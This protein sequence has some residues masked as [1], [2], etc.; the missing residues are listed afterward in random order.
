MKGCRTG[1]RS[2]GP[3][4]IQ[5]LTAIAMGSQS[6]LVGLLALAT[7]GCGASYT[8][9]S[10]LPKSDQIRHCATYRVN[11]RG[12]I[13]IR[14]LTDVEV[15]R[16]SKSWELTY[17][18][19]NVVRSIAR[20]SLGYQLS[21][22]DGDVEHQ[23]VYF[24]GR[25]T[26]IRS[27]TRGQNLRV[28]VLFSN[29]GMR[30]DYV[31][32]W[33]RPAISEKSFHVSELRV[34]D[35]NGFVKE[36]RY[37]GMDGKS[38][39]SS[40]GVYAVHYERQSNGLELRTCFYDASGNAMTSR[41]GVHCLS[42]TNDQFGN[43]GE[44]RYFGRDQRPTQNVFGVHSG[45]YEHD[46]FG[47]LIRTTWYDASG[48]P[49]AT[50]GTP[51]RCTTELVHVKN[52]AI[53][54]GDCYDERNKPNL[55]REGS[56]YW[57]HTVDK[58]G[59]TIGTKWFGVD[60]KPLASPSIAAMMWVYDQTGF[61]T[62]RRY[63]QADGSLR[64]NM[65]PAITLFTRDSHGLVLLEEY[66]DRTKQQTQVFG[67][68]YRQLERDKY[69]QLSRESCL[70]AQ[71]RPTRDFM[72]VATIRY[73]YLDNGLLA[74]SKY[75]DVDGQPVV[76]RAGCA[77]FV[78]KYDAQG[79]EIGREMFDLQD[80]AVI[81]PRFRAIRTRPIDFVEGQPSLGHATAVAR[82]QQARQRLL[83]GEDFATV[84]MQFSDHAISL[85]NPGDVGYFNPVTTKPPV[86]E[87][88][89]NLKVGDVST[90]VEVQDGIHIFQRTE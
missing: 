13:C 6:Y 86:R 90:V 69:R 21:D 33:G 14:E 36:V 48:Q 71:K 25:L 38:A 2:L 50:S 56:A 12:P 60:G 77:K 76:N 18:Q 24:H 28:R 73:R 26:E 11:R 89:E 85:K 80:R 5:P 70:N 41:W 3:L 7:L 59:Q 61:V 47:N 16:R 40:N 53:V 84:A 79:A 9:I 45:K 35:S 54:G 78:V 23:F 34:L 52:G 82:L 20:N 4:P 31:D 42:E 75:L 8:K 27:F 29:D 58:S 10:T 66:L 44:A 22:D 39:K 87:A 43:A 74:E 57:R 88:I 83:E 65:V 49:V 46:E 64:Q 19:G 63:L 55:T 51:G 32:E 67:C 72:G 1:F 62:E 30:T 37:L 17:E 15:N 81:V 68:V